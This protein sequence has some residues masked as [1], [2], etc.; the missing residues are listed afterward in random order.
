MTGASLAAPQW[1]AVELANVCVKKMRLRPQDAPLLTE[2]YGDL[3]LLDVA[4]HPIVPVDVMKL[5][6]ATSLSFY[7]ACYLW[8]AHSLGAELVTL[9]A[10]LA[11]AARTSLP[12]SR[13]HAMPHPGHATRKGPPL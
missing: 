13:Q 9:D 7:D 10:R 3:V 5:A 2:A 6:H 8:L 1:L 11:A 4:L 12:Q